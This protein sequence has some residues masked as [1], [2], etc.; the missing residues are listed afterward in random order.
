MVK[1]EFTFTEAH[2]LESLR[3]HR[4]GTK[5]R[6]LR[7]VLKVICALGL[8]MLLLVAIAAGIFLLGAAAVIFLVCLV[9]GPALDARVMAR[10]FRK[11]PFHDQ[12]C[13]IELGAERFI[14]CD[15]KSRVELSWDAF[16]TAR[17]HENGFVLHTG[18][19][20]FYWLP[21]R[22]LTEG[23][24]DDARQII[25]NSILIKDRT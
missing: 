7:R 11:S 6:H 20:L 9:L 18:P 5:S 3:T 4:N 23:S 15:P 17:R 12:Q 24:I 1:Y 16:T 19:Q 13:R 22:A 25:G 8:V 21:D 10:R 2:F 14:A